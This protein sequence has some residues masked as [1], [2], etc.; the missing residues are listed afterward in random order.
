M[1]LLRTGLALGFLLILGTQASAATNEGWRSFIR[2]E[3]LKGR[4]DEANLLLIDAR[5]AEEYK[6]GHIP[7]AI[8]LPGTNWRTAKAEPNQGENQYVFRKAD[9]SPDVARYEAFLSEAGVSNKHSI[10]VYGNFGGKKDGTVPAFLL[11]WLGHENVS[12]LDGK[13]FEQWTKEGLPISVEE[14]RLPKSN[15]RASAKAEWIWNLDDVQKNLEKEEIVFYD[16]RSKEEFVGENKRSN[17][18]GGHIPGAVLIDYIDLL[19]AQ[20]Q[21]LP[22]EQVKALLTEKGIT[23]EKTVV[24]YC[25]TATRVTLPALALLDLGY[26]NI[27]VYDASWF[28]YGNRDDTKIARLTTQ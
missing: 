1:K 16:T 13:G 8:N 2:L 4:L 25:Q 6:K 15:Y 17:K 21:I 11:R 5:S 7:N 28:E 27:A 12:F 22:P 20:K 24:L 26:Q 19:D 14:R 18:F 23:E 9:G 3:Q 10:V